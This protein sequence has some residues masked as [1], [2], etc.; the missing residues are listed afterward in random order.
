[1]LLTKSTEDFTHKITYAEIW[2]I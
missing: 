1:M 2:I